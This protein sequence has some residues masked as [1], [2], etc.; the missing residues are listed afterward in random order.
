MEQIMEKVLGMDLGTRRRSIEA[1]V[2]YVFTVFATFNLPVPGEQWQSWIAKLVIV[3]V[4]GF[5]LFYEQHYKNND[6][7]ATAAEFT[8]GMRQVKAELGADY[9]GE[10]FYTDLPALEIDGEFDNVLEEDDAIDEI[11]GEIGEVKEDE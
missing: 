9:D 8:G 1:V 10:R 3:L 7:T 5:I 11:E 2:L 4:E 6:H